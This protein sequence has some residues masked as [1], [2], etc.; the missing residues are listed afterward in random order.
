[1]NKILFVIMV[2]VA[3]T[4]CSPFINECDTARC[5]QHAQDFETCGW[6]RGCYEKLEQQ[7]Q[8]EK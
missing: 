4:A 8:S 2:A 1:M 5:Q 6:D 7:R 3:L